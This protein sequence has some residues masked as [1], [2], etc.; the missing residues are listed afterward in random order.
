MYAIENNVWGST[1]HVCKRN[2]RAIFCTSALFLFVSRAEVRS[3]T[4]CTLPLCKYGLCHFD[5]IVI[6]K[7][8]RRDVI[9]IWLEEM[10]ALVLRLFHVRAIGRPWFIKGVL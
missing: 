5:V 4:S 9:T 10:N 7:E 2:V 3:C 6:T 1:L 8:E